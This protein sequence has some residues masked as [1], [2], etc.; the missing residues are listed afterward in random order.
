VRGQGGLRAADLDVVEEVGRLVGCGFADR[1][2]RNGTAHHALGG[3]VRRRVVIGRDRNGR[4]PRPSVR[5]A[6]VLAQLTTLEEVVGPDAIGAKPGRGAQI[7]VDE[8]VE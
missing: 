4:V 8:Y 7:S 1:R 3:A 2:A 5:G 6:D